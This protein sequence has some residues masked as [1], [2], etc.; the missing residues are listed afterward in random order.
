MI[1]CPYCGKEVQ[2]D[3]QV[4]HGDTL[5]CPSCCNEFKTLFV[6]P[7]SWERMQRKLGVYNFL[8]HAVESFSPDGF[9][10]C[11]VCGTPS[12]HGK[13]CR[14]CAKCL[15]CLSPLI[16][17]GDTVECEKCGAKLSTTLFIDKK[18]VLEGDR[19]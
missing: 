15:S 11:A 3:I 19:W 4:T 2:V 12:F 17:D 14:N 6:T 13:I 18:K 8:L 10:F 7:E 1:L 16:L 5:Q 9:H